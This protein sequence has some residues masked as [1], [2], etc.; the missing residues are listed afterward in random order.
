VIGEDP[1][2]RDPAGGDFHADRAPDYGCRV[3][4]DPGSA[5]PV[6]AAT[7]VAPRGIARARLDVGGPID[8]DT[9]WDAAL[10]RVLDAVEVRGGAT[11][12]IAAGARVEFVGFE[13]LAVSDGS[14]QAIGT[15]GAPIVFTSERPEDWQPDGDTR[16][17]WDGLAFVN[18]PADRDTSRLRWCVLE[19]AKALVGIGRAPRGAASG[20]VA[21]D[22]M[23]GAVLVVGGSPVEVSHCVLRR[24]LAERGGAIAV[25]YGAAPLIVNNLV[26]ANYATLRGAGL[27]ASYSY[28]V[29]VHNTF[30]GNETTAPSIFIETGCLDHYHSKPRHL[31]G[32]I[33]DN[34]TTYHDGIQ[35]REPR[36][37][38]TRYCDIE[39]WLGGEG[40]L[41]A[42]PLLDA[43]GE[44]PF[45]PQPGSPVIEAGSAAAMAPWLPALDLAGGPRVV[46]AAPDLGAYEWLDATAAPA[47]Q[48][49]VAS[50]RAAPNP[51]N[52]RTRLSWRQAGPGF[53]RLEIYDASGRRI[54][55]LAEG[56]FGAGPQTVV[57]DGRDSRGRTV[58][59]GLYLARLEIPGGVAV[60][61]VLV[62]P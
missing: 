20:G 46:G 59:A 7:P 14:L 44:P 3:F 38:Y 4:A 61:K 12:T 5:R 21:V 53:A 2:L 55:H 28:P 34:P 8:T 36:A 26:H 31:G 57:W 51:F 9:V 33:W 47:S 1:G 30:V 16:G 40:C 62:S 39:G 43:V 22:A 24:N 50:L 32:I 49:A 13:E 15:P 42:D 58:P 45:A 10:V 52:P 6:T 17:A 37:H 35:I 18:V 48:P 60:T 56:E 23:G 25:H 29:L 41:T 19:C 27:Y 11:L 54:R